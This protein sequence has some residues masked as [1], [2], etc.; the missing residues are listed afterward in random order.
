M[1]VLRDVLYRRVPKELLDRPK[2][3]FSIPI[4]K[5]LREGELRSWAEGLLDENKIRQQGFLD[6][7]VVK[8]FW[9]D[10]VQTGNWK[11]QIWYM[12]MFQQWMEK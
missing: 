8:D 12:L 9:D 3:G 10:F 11:P 2:K 6:A 1:K 7:A 5:W 4:D